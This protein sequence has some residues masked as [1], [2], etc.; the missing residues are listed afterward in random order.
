MRNMKQYVRLSNLFVWVMMAYIVTSDCS[1]YDWGSFPD[2][3]RDFSLRHNVQNDL[4]A[5]SD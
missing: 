3:Y 2:K 4:E 5:H 1:F